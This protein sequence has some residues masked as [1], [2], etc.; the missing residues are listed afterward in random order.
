[1]AVTPQLSVVLH[2]PG[3]HA[4]VAPVIEAWQGQTAAERLELI[5]VT[6]TDGSPAPAGVR[7]IAVGRSAMHE[8]RATG[9]RAAT[10]ELVMLGEDHCLPDPDVAERFIAR[11]AEGW[12]VIG[13][14]IRCADPRTLVARAS[15][16]IGYS[17]WMSPREGAATTVPGHNSVIRRSLLTGLGADLEEE[18]RGSAFL[19]TRLVRAGARGFVDPAIGMRHFDPPSWPY[20]LKLFGCVGLGFGALRTRRWPL[21]ARMLYPLAAP[22]V[23]ARHFLRTHRELRRLPDYPP[24]RFGVALL[25]LA[26]G[27]CEGP[28]ALLGPARTAQA[29]ELTEVKPATYADVERSNAYERG[30]PTP[31]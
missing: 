30:E 17:Q 10:G 18:L 15:V 21:A 2:A 19:A 1:M 4:S 22:A 7:V 11:A 3:G 27:L 26:W 23:V 29:V 20:E 25:A 13:P 5:V 16:A 8:S 6:P 24:T 12:D 14:A 28:G 9:I 31:A